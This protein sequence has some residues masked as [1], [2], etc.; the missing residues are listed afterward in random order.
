MAGDIYNKTP[1]LTGWHQQDIVTT[2]LIWQINIR[3][4]QSKYR[5]VIYWIATTDVMCYGSTVTVGIAAPE[6]VQTG[7]H[8]RIMSFCYM[9]RN[10]SVLLV[11][12]QKENLDIKRLLWESNDLTVNLKF[13]SPVWMCYAIYIIN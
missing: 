10:L 6:W 13:E 11:T 2:V 1:A 7:S 3:W 4:S 5:I 8:A 12:V 9:L